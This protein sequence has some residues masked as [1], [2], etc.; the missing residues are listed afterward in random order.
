M[1]TSVKRS[2]YIDGVSIRLPFQA[3]PSVGSTPLQL[4]QALS[5]A[6]PLELL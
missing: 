3:L 4:S 6:Q 5:P 1:E 2:F